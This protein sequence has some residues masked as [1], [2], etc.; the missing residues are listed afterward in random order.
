MLKPATSQFVG[1]G[2]YTVEQAS[3]LL[4]ITPKRLN[5]WLGSEDVASGFFARMFAAEDLLTFAELMELHFIKMFRD[6]GVSLQTIRKASQAASKKFR[7]VHP[8]LLKRFDTDGKSIF[9]TLQ[10]RENERTVVE[11][12]RRG[13]LVFETIIRPFF[14]KLDYHNDD[15]ERYWPLEKKG[16]IVLDP[17]RMHGKPIDAQTGVPVDVILNSLHAG[18]GQDEQTVAEW[19]GLPQEAIQAAILFEKTLAS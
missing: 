6:E 14:K 3:S 4:G 12:L 8:F 15:V 7:T 13:Q 10:H 16:R 17:M 2:L 1:C 18:D 5:Y 19:L 11:D 9:A